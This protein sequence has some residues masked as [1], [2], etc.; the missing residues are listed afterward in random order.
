MP[1]AP[2]IPGFVL[3]TLEQTIIL[4]LDGSSPTLAPGLWVQDDRV[5][6]PSITHALVLSPERTEA[7]ALPGCPC[8]AL[9]GACDQDGIQLRRFDPRTG[10]LL[11]DQSDDDCACIRQPDVHGF[12][13]FVADDGRAFPACQ[14]E[15]DKAIVSLVGGLLYSIGWDWNGACG[16]SLS[17]YDAMNYD[18]A[19]VADPLPPELTSDGMR[20]VG[21]Y[22]MDAAVI[23]W[24]WPVGRGGEKMEPDDC[25]LDE[26]DIFMIRRGQLWNVRDSMGHAGGWRSFHQRPARPDDCPTINDACGDPEPFRTVAKLDDRKR[27]HWIATDGSMAVTAVKQAY[28]LWKRDAATPIEHEL[29][30]VDATRDLLGVRAHADVGRLRTV[31]AGHSTLGT[32]SSRRSPE[33]IETD[34]CHELYQA[35]EAAKPG[36]PI[37]IPKRSAHA[38][39]E[40]CYSSLR[41]EQWN[42]AEKSCLR[43]LAVAT[44]A[45]TK[46]ALLYNLGRI[47]EAQHAIPQAME[48]YR[49]S[50]AARPGNATVKQRLA[51]LERGKPR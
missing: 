27:E 9:S 3:Y 11:D 20:L 40:D 17:V 28:S 7:L 44:E 41:A 51:K 50:L 5:N 42:W 31:I 16:D 1:D 32:R 22:A 6:P 45:G 37:E 15:S 19:L 46:G 18:L 30:G 12:P 2:P 24:P 13:P 33:T 39:G 36:P 4:P 8:S 48:H 38:W 43:G 34:Q 35:E 25:E 49:D 14:G 26:S 29:P 23:E 47:A 10:A 21:C